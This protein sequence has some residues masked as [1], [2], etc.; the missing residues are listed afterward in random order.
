MSYMTVYQDVG[1][2]MFNLLIHLF[3]TR[4]IIVGNSSGIVQSL[5][6][7]ELWRR[8]HSHVNVTHLT[9]GG[10]HVQCVCCLLVVHRSHIHSL[11]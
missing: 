3:G 6:S 10:S 7:F 4:R 2:E 1:Q 5:S 9:V 11:R 8:R